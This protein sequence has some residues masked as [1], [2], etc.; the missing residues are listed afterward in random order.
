MPSIDI[1]ARLN[2]SG[3]H[4]VK[5]V[6][7]AL[8]RE[9]GNVKVPIQVK[10]DARSSVGVANLTKLLKD[11]TGTAVIANNSIGRLNTSLQSL[12]GTLGGL[13]KVQQS[14]SGIQRTEKA[15][16][17][18]RKVSRESANEIEKFGQSAAFAIRRFS[19]FTVAVGAVFGFVRALQSATS[20]AID[21][22]KQLTRISQIQGKTKSQL[23]PLVNEITKLSTSLGVSSKDLTGVAE[24]LSQAGLS[25]N[26]TRKAL[27]A[28]AKTA[29]APTFNDIKNTTEAAIAAMNQFGLEAKDLEAV[30]GSINS[31]A[32]KFATEAEDL[33]TVIR[34]TGAIF[35]VAGSQLDDPKKQLNE[36][37]S[38]FTAVRSTTRESA[39]TIATGFRTIFSRLQRGDTLEFLRNF[40]IELTDTEGRFVGVFEAVRRL[41]AGLSQFQTGDIQFAEIIKQLAGRGE[42][43]SKVIPLIQQFPKALEAFDV[44][45][46][47]TTSL[48]KDQVIAQ[49]SL[50]NAISRVR[51][52]FLALVRGITQTDTFKIMTKSILGLASSLIKVAETLKPILPLITALAAAKL[53][54]GGTQFFKGFSGELHFGG[55]K[56]I[57]GKA[58]GGYVPGEGDGDSVLS[59]LTPGEFIINKSA[60][61]K[62]GP[63]VLNSL[64]KYAKG[65]P[66]GGGGNLVI[67]GDVDSLQINVGKLAK[68]IQDFT[69][70]LRQATASIRQ[71]IISKSPTAAAI[72][73]RLHPERLHEF[74]LSPQT[75]RPS[76]RKKNNLPLVVAKRLPQFDSDLPGLAEDRI[77]FD[78][79]PNPFRPE[80]TPRLRTRR[81]GFGQKVVS[82]A[83][84]LFNDNSL[85]PGT[86]G[87]ASGFNFR[88]AGSALASS[89]P[90]LGT[91][92]PAGANAARATTVSK[93]LKNLS[94][95]QREL[96][97][98]A[99]ALIQNQLD[100]GLSE[101]KALQFVR[102]KLNNRGVKDLRN[103]IDIGAGSTA[104]IFNKQ[105]DAK[106]L[107]LGG[108]NGN[109][110]AKLARVPISNRIGARL[111]SIGSSIKSNVTSQNGRSALAFGGFLAASQLEGKGTLA[112][113]AAS[114]I[115]GGLA[116]GSIAGGA[117]G[118]H[119]GAVVGVTVGIVSALDR[120]FSETNRL[121]KEA[122][123]I[124]FDEILNRLADSLKKGTAN[125]DG[126]IDE[127]RAKIQ[128]D[129]ELNTDSGRSLDALAG[130]ALGTIHDFISGG[131]T[132][133]G[134][135]SKDIGRT[136]GASGLIKEQIANLFGTQNRGNSK[137]DEAL[138]K[139][140]QDKLK[141]L[142]NPQFN[143]F[144]K[145]IQGGA[146]VRSLK[147]SESQKNL[148]KDAGID[149]GELFQLDKI[150]QSQDA[151]SKLIH[152]IE[153][154]GASFDQLTAKTEADI[155][156][157]DEYASHQKKLSDI[158]AGSTRQSGA[159]GKSSAVLGNI[160]GF[161]SADV[162]TALL[163]SG[164]GGRAS[165]II[166]SG[167]EALQKVPG[168][169]SGINVASDPAAAKKQLEQQIGAL[170]LDKA[171]ED[172]ILH[173]IRGIDIAGDG[174]TEFREKF[175][176]LA[177]NIDQNIS[178]VV[179]PALKTAQAND[180]KLKAISDHY[181]ESLN[182]LAEATG[183]FRDQVFEAS[184]NKLEGH[185]AIANASGRELTRSESLSSLTAKTS[186]LGITSPTGLG[187]RIAGLRNR[188]AALTTARE[189][190][191]NGSP[192][193]KELSDKL[194]AV[195]DELE[196]SGK[197]LDLFSKDTTLATLAAERLSKAETKRQVGREIAGGILG[198]NKLGFAKQISALSK[199]QSGDLTPLFTSFEDLQAAVELQ[200]KFLRANGKEAEA[201]KVETGFDA[202]I[203]KALGPEFAALFKGIREEE[204]KAREDQI[205]AA[206]T[207]I[208]ASEESIK[209]SAAALEFYR[210]G[211]GAG[212]RRAGGGRIYGAGTG[213]S[214]SIPARL[215]NGE[216]VIR[217]AAVDR[218]GV[219]ALDHMNAHGEIPG[220]A[221]GGSTRQIFRDR[222]HKSAIRSLDR[223]DRLG[224]SGGT[225]FNT[226][227]AVASGSFTG[228]SGTTFDLSKVGVRP[229]GSILGRASR[230][231]DSSIYR[232]TRKS[233]SDRQKARHNAFVKRRGFASGGLVGGSGGI[234]LGE[235]S[236]ASLN[237]FV[238]AANSLA[239]TLSSVNIPS[240]IQMTG[241][242]NVNVTLNGASVLSELMNG[243]LAGLVRDEINRAMSNYDRN[244][245]G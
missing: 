200:A 232:S 145:Q 66:V 211:V 235:G 123:Q 16:N 121:A 116:A 176:Q 242:H 41:N 33:T 115:S 100:R 30:F 148:F 20:E 174:E 175:R 22:D 90:A 112:S 218:L 160:A 172:S 141:E 88:G 237:N 47:G 62:L 70:S 212:P 50:A 138:Q 46:K 165:S 125:V 245:K 63:K 103:S 3:P 74:A 228:A 183:R 184:D 19:A 111:G 61:N 85:I 8:Q 244:L 82:R 81:Q 181:L 163:Q 219:D 227:R 13:G 177:E 32:A 186:A 229:F 207:S 168:I 185:K 9:L 192:E 171:I 54:S 191:A 226:V 202:G 24:T 2:L 10:I 14:L 149:L 159:S 69:G 75:I 15:L 52:E 153:V 224:R 93:L 130:T 37:L 83:G 142:A 194:A 169:F 102:T 166:N 11:L 71:D 209:A 208:T 77:P 134:D 18:V 152:N 158:F 64:N 190:V 157:I 95:S 155:S 204:A 99:G 139:E 147:I 210:G 195:N 144:K 223:K 198:G 51:E 35:A 6:V 56:K 156:I 60:A 201:R 154:L 38:L 173:D 80:V 58:K 65:G 206:T 84:K 124:K 36:L 151:L 67:G 108:F 135:S 164:T 140:Q 101:G 42:Q 43:V 179:D 107:E 48:T 4:N 214:D 127:G 146:D 89:G 221:G 73:G 182:G 5:P 23:A 129:K 217:A 233:F 126:I 193:F 216:Y 243:P 119:A 161:S 132:I 57:P 197:A 187:T 34:K 222:F 40:N 236:I 7:A 96:H 110:P 188:A 114:G 26:D 238:I 49:E 136:Q 31:V 59:R 170:H 68:V 79:S 225:R 12:S 240:T 27:A 97:K 220:F 203:G 106:L 199:F 241:T 133:G 53:A 78:T 128:K 72:A 205:K 87:L 178:K 213:T 39:D 120:F 162:K 29:L 113:S 180:K 28:L 94:P 230:F 122:N 109:S 215:S 45:N 55:G 92:N 143:A 117:L 150:R 231:K 234:N 98:D 131:T 118:G 25:A 105:T 167:K 104:K 17:G 239:N 91:A 86:L 137:F 196:R 44:A 76:E 21:F 1:K 189:G